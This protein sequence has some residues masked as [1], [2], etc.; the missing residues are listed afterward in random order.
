MDI[1]GLEQK[2][3]A[4]VGRTLPLYENSRTLLDLIAEVHSIHKLVKVRNPCTALWHRGNATSFARRP[5]PT[6]VPLLAAACP[7]LLPSPRWV[8]VLAHPRGR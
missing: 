3:I 4:E 7:P 6:G 2:A 1:S 5:L 8:D